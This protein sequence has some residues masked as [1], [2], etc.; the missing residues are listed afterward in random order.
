MKKPDIAIKKASIKDAE[1]LFQLQ[2][3][4]YIS[5]A[6]IY[7]DYTIPPLIQ[8]LEE[9][10]ETFKTYI[11]LKAVSG[12]KIIGSVRGEL[13][14]DYVYIGR[15]MVHPD[16]QGHGLGTRLM[17]T[18]EAE[19]P[20]IKKFALATGHRSERNLYLYR[21]LGFKIV[22]SEIVNDRLTLVHLE[23]IIQ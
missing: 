2:K 21:K 3:L 1:E 7:N 15:L 18:I 11:I 16:Y 22:H 13:T 5:E 9:S 6:K 10:R 12:G 20:Q 8:S 14:D 23:K 19:F 17:Q 4:A